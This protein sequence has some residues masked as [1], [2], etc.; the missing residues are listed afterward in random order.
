MARNG[1]DLALVSIGLSALFWYSFLN[2]VSKAWGNFKPAEIIDDLLPEWL[3]P[4]EDL[5]PAQRRA[6]WSE[7]TMRLFVVEM[8]YAGVDPRLVLLG[9]SLLS[10]FRA[11]ERVGPTAGLL[12]TRDSHLQEVGY[13]GAP[14]FE[15][16]TAP[17]QF[18]WLRKVLAYRIADR[19]GTAPTTLP[20]LLVLLAPF[21]EHPRIEAYIRTH[22]LLGQ[23][24][25]ETSTVFLEHEK[26]LRRVQA[27][28]PRPVDAMGNP[29]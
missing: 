4:K 19:G 6:L 3:K 14:T 15:T 21:P 9:I 18:P 20:D 13:P 8:Q 25:A 12:L 22:A 17:Q 5:T 29:L 27:A 23:K 11:D 16:L 1:T 28:P 10:N 26:L 2:R 24:R 7:S